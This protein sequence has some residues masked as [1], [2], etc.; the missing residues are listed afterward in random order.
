MCVRLQVLRHPAV[1]AG[2][3]VPA[4]HGQ[5]RADK[6]PFPGETT[7][8]A[9]LQAASE[10]AADKARYVPFFFRFGPEEHIQAERSQLYAILGDGHPSLIRPTA[11]AQATC[12][13]S[14]AIKHPPV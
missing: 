11:P 10:P 3:A 4:G 6:R 2:P 9:K 14:P 13:A 1:S 12:R 8:E 5:I 7:F